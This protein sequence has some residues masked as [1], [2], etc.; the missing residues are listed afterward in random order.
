[1]YTKVNTCMPLKQKIK[2]MTTTTLISNLEEYEFRSLKISSILIFLDGSIV[3]FKSC[4]L[5]M[6]CRSICHLCCHCCS[7]KKLLLI[8][9]KK[10]K[11][12]FYQ[13]KIKR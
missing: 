4:L 1:M 11:A 3:S 10:L 7:C 13:E 12:H 6:E 2:L 9:E 8:N 5:S